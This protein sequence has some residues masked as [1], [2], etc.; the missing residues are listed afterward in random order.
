[1]TWYLGY[2]AGGKTT[3]AEGNGERILKQFYVERE[4]N[5]ISGVECYLPMKIEF[6]RRGKDRYAKP[7]YLPRWKN[8]LFIDVPDDLFGKVIETK[9]L[10]RQMQPFNRADTAAMPDMKR[11]TEQAI[12]DAERIIANQDAFSE[13]EIGTR[14]KIIDGT[15][16]DKTMVFQKM[17][18]RANDFFP[19]I[20][21]EAELFGRKTRVEVD[22]L[23]VRKADD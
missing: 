14:L 18:K 19:R 3:R 22:P 7:E 9:Y 17:I 12:A 4:V 10:A 6:M 21:G 8:Y 16:E 20:V 13:Y 15:F 2:V 11:S 5:R 23:S 1:M